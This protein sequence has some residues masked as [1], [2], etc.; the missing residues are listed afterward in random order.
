M[1][2]LWLFL[3]A[4]SGWAQTETAAEEKDA[5][6][7]KE[8]ILVNAKLSGKMDELMKRTLQV[9]HEDEGIAFL[10]IKG[11]SYAEKTQILFFRKRGTRLQTIATGLVA[12]EQR[13]RSTGKKELLVKI[14]KDSIVKYPQVGDLAVPLADP[15]AKG[16]GDKKDAS[17]MPA[18]VDNVEKKKDYEGFFEFS[19]GKMMGSYAIDYQNGPNGSPPTA[20][21][22]TVL[23]ANR[24]KVTRGYSFSTLHLAYYLGLF[25]LGIEFDSHSGSFPTSSEF[26]LNT[27]FTSK[28]SVS[29]LSLNY[30]LPKFFDKKFVVLPRLTLLS[31]HYET[32]NAD[33]GVLNTKISGLGLGA[34]L[35]YEPVSPVW[36]KQKNEFF[37]QIQN[38]FAEYN[39]YPSLSAT[40]GSISRGTSSGSTGSQYRFG[41]TV[42]FWLDFVP[43]I[44]RWIINASYGA[45][46]Y[47]L[48]FSGPTVNAPPIAL[49]AGAG[50]V[51]AEKDYRI[52][53]GFRIDD[54]LSLLFSDK[55][56]DK[57]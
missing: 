10:I 7:P 6:P 13:N 20:N 55:K 11:Q 16:E 4:R 36:K 49:P 29:T 15:T 41:G 1:L 45:R 57:K 39:F 17:L 47:N 33:E 22:G 42:L 3:S 46:S 14:D 23:S 50:S 19:F 52:L 24:G 2:L 18:P 9:A 26:F 25:P 8:N 53:V 54:P 44:K 34:R 32:T 21:N 56:K 12:A 37:I 48:K 35:V 27:Q 40:D 5:P 43:L 51:E 38:L 31:D 28:E 30:R